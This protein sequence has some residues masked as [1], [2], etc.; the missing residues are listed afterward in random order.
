MWDVKSEDGICRPT[1]M[2][3][4]GHIA[5]ERRLMGEWDQAPA[6]PLLVLLVHH[7]HTGEIRPEHMEPLA[8]RI[9]Q[10]MDVLDPN[11]A[12]KARRFV[13]GLRSALEAGEPVKFH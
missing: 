11:D 1:V 6:D 8:M 2:I 5:T 9:E 12:I 7:D 13:D 3:D 4:W 10:L